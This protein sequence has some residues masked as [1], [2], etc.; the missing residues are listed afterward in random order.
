MEDIKVVSFSILFV[1]K[2]TRMQRQPWTYGIKGKLLIIND[3]PIKAWNYINNSNELQILMCPQATNSISPQ[4]CFI[5]EFNCMC[6]NIFVAISLI[7]HKKIKWYAEEKKERKSLCTALIKYTLHAHGIQRI[8][9]YFYHLWFFSCIIPCKFIFALF[10]MK[11]CRFKTQHTGWPIILFS[12]RTAQMFE[13]HEKIKKETFSVP[14]CLKNA[15]RIL[16]THRKIISLL[17]LPFSRA[18]N[19]LTQDFVTASSWTRL[20]LSSF[21][22]TAPTLHMTLIAFTSW[23][24]AQFSGIFRG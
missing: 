6:L 3:L 15:T 13:T 23:A 22:F 7:S 17:F 4:D 12:H 14:D 18:G 11:S 1:C 9:I 8:N 20:K 5:Y 10:R 19:W 2:E 16:S 21:D 24:S